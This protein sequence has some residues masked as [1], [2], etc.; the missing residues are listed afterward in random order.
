MLNGPVLE[1]Y[2]GSTRDLSTMI[3]G[4]IFEGHSCQVGQAGVCDI[5]PVDFEMSKGHFLE[6][7][8]SLVGDPLTIEQA[9]KFELHTSQKAQTCVCN[10]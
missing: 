6:V 4:E 7:P 3:H 5:H 9:E 1:I 8:Q 2:Q 10:T